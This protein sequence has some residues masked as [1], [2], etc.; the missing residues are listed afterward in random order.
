M[1]VS[2]ITFRRLAPF[3]LSVLFLL[4]GSAC[5]EGSK[6][7]VARPKIGAAEF[8][9]PGTVSWSAVPNAN[10]TYRV[11]VN[12]VVDASMVLARVKALSTA[13]LDRDV[14]CGD[15][16]KV[17]GAAAKI[18]G[19]A[20]LRYDVRFSY[21][22]RA[23]AAGVPVSVSSVI[24]CFARVAVTAARSTVVIDVKG[25]RE[26]PCRIDGVYQSVSD[27]VYA[28]VGIDV[29]KRHTINLAALL[30]PEFKGVTINI[31]S[32]TFDQPPAPAKVRI[33]G[34]STMSVSQY[35]DLTAR[36]EAALPKAN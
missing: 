5:A 1:A 36:L 9:L 19:S 29:F 18:V 20:A 25:A 23:C 17:L 16:V 3:A 27:A 24:T 8:P 28:I 11:S 35:K 30:P 4:P 33:A 34:E 31:R 10:G 7:F 2:L 32:L 13:A 12:A 15:A 6:I 14:P 26:P 21:V 22:K